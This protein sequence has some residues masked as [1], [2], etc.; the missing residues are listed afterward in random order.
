M[1]IAAITPISAGKRTINAVA[2][3][4]FS[5]IFMHGIFEKWSVCFVNHPIRDMKISLLTPANRVE[6]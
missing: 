6:L 2:L 3:A 4:D 5:N 1:I